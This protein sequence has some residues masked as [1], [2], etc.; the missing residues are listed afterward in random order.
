MGVTN[1][2]KIREKAKRKIADLIF[3]HTSF[4][5]GCKTGNELDWIL[6]HSFPCCLANP[7]EIL[8]NKEYHNKYPANNRIE[9]GAVTIYL[10]DVHLQEFG[11]KLRNEI[12]QEI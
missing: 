8:S 5:N 10:C 9:M 11:E 2:R 4:P 6:K 1:F 3:R 12:I 7:I